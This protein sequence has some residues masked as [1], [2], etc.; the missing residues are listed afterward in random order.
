M[1]RGCIPLAHPNMP[2]F[3]FPFRPVELASIVFALPLGP[4]NGPR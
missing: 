3:S 2:Y 1:V 4:M